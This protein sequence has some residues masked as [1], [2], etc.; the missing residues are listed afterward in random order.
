VIHDRRDAVKLAM[1]QAAR[2][3]GEAVALTGFTW[4]DPNHQ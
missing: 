3:P 2:L 4:R 1:M